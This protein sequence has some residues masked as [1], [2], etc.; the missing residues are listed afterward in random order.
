[1]ANV[2]FM[3]GDTEKMDNTAIMDGLIFFNTEENEMFL[4]DG[5]TRKQF[6]GAGHI[7]ENNAGTD[8]AKR[9]NMQFKGAYV[10]DDSENNRTKVNV[11]RKMTD[12]EFSQLTE[13]EKQ[14]IIK[15]TTDNNLPFDATMVEYDNT[16]SDLSSTTVQ[17]AIDELNSDIYVGQGGIE[18]L[19]NVYR[20]KKFAGT[21]ASAADFTNWKAE[22]GITDG[23]FNNIRLGDIITIND[24]TVTCD[25][26]VAGF[27]TEL[28]KGS[29]NIISTNHVAFI[30]KNVYS[31]S[32]MNGSNVTTG[33]FKGAS[34]MW[35]TLDTIVSR[36]N[37][38]LGSSLLSRDILITNT[39]DNTKASAAGAGYT[40]SST[41]WEW[42]N[43]KITLLSE[44]QVYGSTVFSSS[45]MDVGEGFE[46]LPIFNFI[47]PTYYG[48]STWWL[49]AVASSTYFC[50]VGYDGVAVNTGA[51]YS[52]GVRPLIIVG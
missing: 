17:G 25:W 45:G 44:V 34:T 1:M 30:P 37:N 49:R 6:S 28:N 43:S 48:R 14:G 50:S 23:S 40:G 15:T 24:G 52:Y 26:L 47:T 12:T 33:G 39:V 35:T 22:A 27:N 21:I 42:K 10:E 11:I 46:K 41:N 5:N 32:A 13:A 8:M 36:L 38:I 16:Q 31:N 18:I 3:R 2:N 51:S 20:G 9:R 29:T 4:D 19:N 7:I